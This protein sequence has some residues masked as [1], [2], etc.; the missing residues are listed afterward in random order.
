[1]AT[2][3]NGSRSV[4]LIVDVQVGVMSQLW[5]SSRIIENLARLVER[6]RTASVPVIWVRHCA[7]YLP[8][9]RPEWQFVP[10]LVPHSTERV[11]EKEHNSAFER[12]TLDDELEAIGATHIILAGAA[13]NWCIRATAYGALGRG[14]DLTLVADA[15]TTHAMDSESSGKIP[16][17]SIIEELNVVMD[18][19]RY[20][21]CT[22]R[23]AK[24]EDV[25]FAA[26]PHGE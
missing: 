8:A 21:D 10:E 18:W 19:L 15:H 26:T 6:A 2:I 20:P 11:I 17:K 13:T 24:V 4:L 9:G 1:M 23:T 12:T 25:D 7:E 14:Y 16:A 22:C 3:R 5:D